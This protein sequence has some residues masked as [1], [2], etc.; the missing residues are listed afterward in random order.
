MRHIKNIQELVLYSA[1]SCSLAFFTRMFPY[2]TYPTIM[3][4]LGLA[5]YC[6]YIIGTIEGEHIVVNLILASI[7]LGW[8]GGYWDHIHLIAQY[9]TQAIL[10]TITPVFVALVGYWMLRGLG[11]KARV[12]QKDEQTPQKV[13]TD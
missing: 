7:F 9:N 3:L 10:A 12:S 5:G 2:M 8:L 1:V 13:S 6:L 11:T 4:R